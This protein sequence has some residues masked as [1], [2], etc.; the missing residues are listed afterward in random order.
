MLDTGSDI[1]IISQW[2]KNKFKIQNFDGPGTGVIAF[3]DCSKATLGFI[4]LEVEIETELY[5]LDFDV[6]PN[7]WVSEDMI[8][9]KNILQYAF[10]LIEKGKL[11]RYKD[12]VNDDKIMLAQ[13]NFIKYSQVSKEFEKLENP[14]LR[15][16]VQNLISSYKPKSVEASCI[17]MHIYLEDEKLIYQKPRRLAPKE[18]QIVNMQIQD[19]WKVA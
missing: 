16:T 3:G 15:L 9:G 12:K 4:N 19:G 8:L 2:V 10:I 1:S 7:N 13:V 11:M 14:D 18:S 5:Q 6:V 17:K